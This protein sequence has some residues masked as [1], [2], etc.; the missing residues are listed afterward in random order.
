M[1][2]ASIGSTAAALRS[3]PSR[4]R[5]RGAVEGLHDVGS[6]ESPANSPSPAFAAGDMHTRASMGRKSYDGL[7]RRTSEE[8]FGSFRGS[9]GGQNDSAA[10]A[11]IAALQAQLDQLLAMQQQQDRGGGGGGGRDLYSSHDGG[12]QMRPVGWD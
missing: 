7:R 10:A 5:R 1:F 8:S 9:G 2:Q 4:R 6:T 11:Q 12:A 3:I